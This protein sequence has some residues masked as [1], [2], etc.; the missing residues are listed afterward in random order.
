VLHGGIAAA[1][2]LPGTH[3]AAW[4]LV[5]ALACTLLP[6]ALSLVALRRLTAFQAQ[7]AVNLGAGVRG[8]AGGAAARRAARARPFLLSRRRDHPWASC[9]RTPG[10][11]GQKPAA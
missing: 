6:F 1:L 2:P 9:S 3:D 8:C 10:W 5:L 7:L 4:L 11:F